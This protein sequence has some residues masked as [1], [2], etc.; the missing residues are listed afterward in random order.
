MNW[1]WFN[2]GLTVILGILNEIK[3]DP[4]INQD[5]KDKIKKPMLKLFKTIK[6]VYFDDSD[7]NLEV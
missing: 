3:N 6:L 1:M 5:K 7:F 4:T 2:V